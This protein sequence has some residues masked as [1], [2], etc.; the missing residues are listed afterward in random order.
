MM[1]EKESDLLFSMGISENSGKSA[2]SL[3][4]NAP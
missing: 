4:Y 2:S 3:L 1:L